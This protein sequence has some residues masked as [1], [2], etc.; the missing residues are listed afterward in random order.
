[1]AAEVRRV[2]GAARSGV[3]LLA[4]AG[5]AV[6][7]PDEDGA[8]RGELERARGQWAAQRVDDYRYTVRRLCFCLPEYTGP[9][10]VTVRDGRAAERRYAEGGAAV[11]A[12]PSAYFPPV[13][14]LFEVVEDAIE[15]DA[16]VI[17]VDYH[18]QLGYPTRISIDYDQRIADEEVSYTAEGLQPL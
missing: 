17:D 3:L 12:E 5:C 10:V 13:E 1:M 11:G 16:A 14:G 8:A 4:L 7:G 18:P 2:R 6:T 9:V 15:R